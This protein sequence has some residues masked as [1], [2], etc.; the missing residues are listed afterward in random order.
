[1]RGVSETCRHMLKQPHNDAE[2]VSF[3]QGQSSWGLGC[4]R[5]RERREGSRRE[6][7]KTHPRSERVDMNIVQ[8]ERSQSMK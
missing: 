3:G 1:M 7:E 4:G 2:L 8:L 5:E 6:E